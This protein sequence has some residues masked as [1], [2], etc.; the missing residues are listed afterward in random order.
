MRKFGYEAAPFILG[1]VLGPMFEMSFRQSLIYSY[2][3]LSIFFRRPISA[4]VV[5]LALLLIASSIVGIRRSR[6]KVEKAPPYGEFASLLTLLIFGIAF[7]VKS[8]R[9]RVGSPMNPEPGFFPAILGGVLALLAV[10]ALAKRAINKTP[11]KGLAKNPWMGLKWQKSM[12]VACSL[13][14]YVILF[15]PAGF[16]LSTLL[17]LEFLFLLG[18][19]KKWPLGTLGAF[20][21][22][23]TCYFLF[24]FLLDVQLPS[25]IIESLL[26]IS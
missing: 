20:L 1:F 6:A 11:P 4:V 5:V 23:G 16:L 26:G 24:K 13:I 15:D 10:V 25:G 2:G 22:S 9:Y 21:S 14:G 19:P 8:I 3:D 17:L 12:L 18:N 7:L